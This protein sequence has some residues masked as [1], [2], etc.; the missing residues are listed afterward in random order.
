MSSRTSWPTTAAGKVRRERRIV[1]AVSDIS[2]TIDA[3]E[4]VGYIGPNGAGKS[5]TIKMLTGIL[6]PTS[7]EIRVA[8]LDPQRRRVELARRIG[9]VFG[10]RTQLWWDL[11]LRDSFEL[12]RHVYRVP[13]ARHAENL[14][15]FTERARP[16]VVPRHAGAPALARSTHAR[17]DHRRA[18]PRPV[19]ALPRRA[20]HRPRRREPGT[21]PRVPPTCEPRARASPSCSR[22][23]TSTTSNGCAS[24]L[25][26]IDE[27]R[28]IHDGTVDEV[29]DQYVQYRTLVV[30]LVEPAPPLHDRRTRRSC[31]S[32]GRASGCASTV[33]ASPR[34]SWSPRWRAA[35]TCATSPSRSPTSKTS[36]PASTRGSRV[37]LALPSSTLANLHEQ[38][39][40]GEPIR[41]GSAGRSVESRSGSTA[42]ATTASATAT[43]GPC[44]E[45]EQEGDGVDHAAGARRAGAAGVRAPGHRPAA[46]RGD[47]R[48]GRVVRGRRHCAK[49]GRRPA[50]SGSSSCGELAVL[51]VRGEER[52]VF[53]LRAT[54]EM[55]DRWQVMTPDGGGLVWWCSWLPIDDAQAALHALDRTWQLEWLDVA[56]PALDESAATDP[57]VRARPPLPPEFEGPRGWEE[58]WAYPFFDCRFVATYDDESIPT[59]ACARAGSASLRP[60]TCCWCS[61]TPICGASRA[62]AAKWASRRRRRSCARC[63]KRRVRVSSSR[64]S[65]PRC[66]SP[67]STSTVASGSRAPRALLGA[68]RGGAVGGRFRDD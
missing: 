16:R 62:A 46:P 11:P 42:S 60:V 2:L 55:I 56:R 10:Q 9:V 37:S 23:T 50:R 66:G 44:D 40:V 26:V 45:C 29:K 1:H 21:R 39:A 27:G 41:A 8:G 30:D 36:S 64:A 47:G 68:D 3:G 24:R 63:G 14:V 19:G 51:D 32:T 28:I 52:H 65:S 54:V 17:G 13:A 22:P 53:H 38:P 5:T 20:D 49:D 6:V 35:A 15:E 18:A 57:P 48:G 7:G 67:A 25:V 33:I 59:T 58:F 4:C 12:L 34:R 43:T 31:G 61:T